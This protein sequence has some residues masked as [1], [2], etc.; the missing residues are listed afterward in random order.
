MQKIIHG[1]V[2]GKTIEL[3]QDPG[4][5]DGATVRIVMKANGSE[6][7]MTVSAKAGVP[8]WGEGIRRS[9]GGWSDHPEMD[10]VMERIHQERRQERRSQVDQ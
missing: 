2:H 6:L 8:P 1:V 7:E 3:T 9:A 10:A 4:V 5:P